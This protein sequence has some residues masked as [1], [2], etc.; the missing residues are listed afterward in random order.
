MCNNCGCNADPFAFNAEKKNCGCGQDPCV[1]Y[2]AESEI[3]R[4]NRHMDEIL[5]VKARLLEEN[6]GDYDPNDPEQ[7]AENDAIYEVFSKYYPDIY[8]AESLEDLDKSQL[9]DLIKNLEDRDEYVKGYV[10]NA[11]E[12]WHNDDEGWD[13]NIRFD[14]Y[15]SSLSGKIE[16]QRQ[17]LDKEKFKQAISDGYTFYD[18]GDWGGHPYRFEKNGDVIEIP[19]VKEE[20]IEL[21]GDEETKKG[22]KKSFLKSL[23]SKNAESEDDYST[24]CECEEGEYCEDTCSVCVQC[25]I[26]TQTAHTPFAD[27]R[28]WPDED[29]EERIN[30]AKGKDTWYEDK[31]CDYCGEWVV[32]NRSLNLTDE[33]GVWN[34]ATPFGD[35]IF[36]PRLKMKSFEKTF[37]AEDDGSW[38]DE[39]K[40]Q[41][42][43]NLWREKEWANE[44]NDEEQTDYW[45]SLFS[46]KYE[47]L[48]ASEQQECQDILGSMGAESFGAEGGDL[49]IKTFREGWE[50]LGMAKSRTWISGYFSSYDAAMKDAKEEKDDY[51]KSGDEII[52]F[53]EKDGRIIIDVIGEK[54]TTMIIYQKSRKLG[55]ESFGAE[56]DSK[57]DNWTMKQWQSYYG[58]PETNAN[59]ADCSWEILQSRGV[60]TGRKNTLITEV[61]VECTKCKARR[62]VV[63]RGN[64]LAD[65]EALSSVARDSAEMAAESEDDDSTN[66]GVCE[67]KIGY[68]GAIHYEELE[69]CEKCYEEQMERDMQNYTHD[70]TDCI[71]CGFAISPNDV[72][73]ELVEGL[74]PDC[75]EYK[76]NTGEKVLC[77]CSEPTRKDDFCPEGGYNNSGDECKF[78]CGHEE[79]EAEMKAKYGA[80]SFGAEYGKRQRFGN[81]YVG[82]DTKGKFISNVSVGRSLKADRRTKSKTPARS[83]FGHKGDTQKGASAGF[84]LPT[85]AKSVIGIGAVLGG[86]WAYLESQK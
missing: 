51:E 59:Y 56:Y 23:F 3:D 76:W 44:D 21:D 45:G 78:E 40:V 22:A 35:K 49:Y 85:D 84:K 43:A 70:E 81:R 13:E 19:V 41:E 31:G 86:L 60:Y 75:N 65:G 68:D 38:Q 12:E 58:C 6:I 50:S 66:C 42:C 11:A 2:G 36:V 29:K 16:S 47:K 82:R 18:Y 30:A 1:T 32:L 48:S 20:I 71:S 77:C 62:Y 33:P 83:G 37:G 9:I 74:C 69:W 80:E 28:F 57:P 72:R 25:G 15:K 61:L 10:E 67:V 27:E 17:H 26:R 63:S 34:K 4:Y 14:N 24:S 79:C 52:G 55:A 8:G 5:E 73:V 39:N 46:E 54:R 7:E 53:F 64:I